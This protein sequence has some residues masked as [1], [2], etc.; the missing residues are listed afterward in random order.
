M[1]ETLP[2]VARCLGC[3][4]ELRGLPEPVCPEC[5]RVFDPTD[6]TTFDTRTD[7]QRRRHVF[8]RVAIVVAVVGLITAFAPRGIMKSTVTL[9]C[10]DCKAVYRTTRYELKSPGWLPFRYPGFFW[11][12]G[13]SS[14]EPPPDCKH[15]RYDVSTNVQSRVLLGCTVTG[16]TD[17]G[18]MCFVNEIEAVPGNCGDIIEAITRDNGCSVSCGL[19]SEGEALARRTR[20]R[21]EAGTP[22]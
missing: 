3:G 18:T 21:D 22:K 11:H 5:G 7:A 15:H 2:S 10:P 8:R 19:P 20:M 12:S 13:L 6:P 17:P 9:K 14:D 4:Y 16:T 1:T